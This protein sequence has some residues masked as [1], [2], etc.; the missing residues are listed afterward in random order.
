M[1]PETARGEAAAR[2][3]S[4][5]IFLEER[6]E[7]EAQLARFLRLC[8]LACTAQTSSPCQM[9]LERRDFLESKRRNPFCLSDGENKDSTRRARGIWEGQGHRGSACCGEK[10]RRCTESSDEA[11]IQPEHAFQLR[12]NLRHLRRRDGSVKPEAKSGQDSLEFRRNSQAES[13]A[14]SFSAFGFHLL[15]Q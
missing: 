5:E 15:V 14:R 6:G 9:S 12:E 7:S 10:I 3:V 2:S 13:R 4:A 8:C 1:K 11:A